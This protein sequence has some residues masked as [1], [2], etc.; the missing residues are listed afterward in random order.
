M[1]FSSIP[2]LQE[3][4]AFPSSDQKLLQPTSSI[5]TSFP[6]LRIQS[7]FNQHYQY[8]PKATTNLLPDICGTLRLLLQTKRLYKRKSP[9][10][11]V[12]LGK[13][14]LDTMRNKATAATFFQT[15]RGLIRRQKKSSSR[16]FFSYLELHSIHQ[17]KL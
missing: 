17:R 4:A 7:K 14:R 5:L 16:A 15:C 9:V 2:L 12:S 10:Y 6:G 11:F 1:R 3:T 13:K 8:H